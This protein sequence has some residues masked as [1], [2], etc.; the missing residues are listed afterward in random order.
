MEVLILSKTHF[1]NSVCVGGVVLKSKQY[2]RLL[3]PGGWYQYADTKFNIGD[4]W[5]I[6]FKVSDNIVE[7]HNE[8]VIIRSQTYV[9][10]ITDL[11]QYIVNSGLSIWRGPV[12]EIFDS[13]LIWASTG[14]GY[15]SENKP[16]YPKHSV[17]FWISD[18]LLTYDGQEH[19]IYSMRVRPFERKLKYK[20]IPDAIDTIPANTLLRVSLPK[21]WKHPDSDVEK[22]C[23]VQLSGWY[24]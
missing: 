11:S 7:P 21:W 9:R 4:V 17:G 12:T 23:Y 24:D 20:G 1:G 14:A 3:N 18:R 15:L 5:D 22:R 13:K 2:V 6:E 19:Y 8:D 16:D 10:S